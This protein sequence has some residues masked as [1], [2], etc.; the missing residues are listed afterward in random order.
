LKDLGASAGVPVP[1]PVPIPEFRPSWY[2]RVDGG[3]GTVSEP[4]TSERGF[5]FG[6]TAAEGGPGPSTGP[7]QTMTTLSSWFDNDF[8]TFATFGGGVGYYFGGGFR[9]DATIEARSKDDVNMQGETRWDTHSWYQD[10]CGTYVYGTDANANGVLD[11]RSKM[12]VQER[13]TLDGT[14]WMLNGYYD[15]A[16]VRGFTPYVGAG[17]G[18]IWNRIERNHTSTYSTCDNEGTP[19]DNCA[20]NTW[21]TQNITEASTHADTVS[22]AAAA[23][24]GFSYDLTD[25]TAIDIGYRYL[26][27]GGTSTTMNIGG[28]D[29]RLTIGDQNVHQVRAGLRINVD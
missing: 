25:M 23:M 1:A 17:V 11:S 19:P 10:C 3:V 6:N 9:M 28:D 15:F 12:E 16:N 24:A 8:N 5:V 14:I 22:F 4:S 26:H 27:L 13:A 7:N 21:V 18:F 2:F 20:N 29:S